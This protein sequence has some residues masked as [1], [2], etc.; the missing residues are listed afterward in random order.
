MKY[1]ISDARGEFIKN[2]R[3]DSGLYDTRREAEIALLAH[4]DAIRER[5]TEDYGVVE[6][7]EEIEDTDAL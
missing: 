7:A 6:V 3:Y 4:V 2:G 1:A 5:Q